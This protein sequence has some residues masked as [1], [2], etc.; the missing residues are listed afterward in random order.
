MVVFL[1]MWLV[2]LF[3]FCWHVFGWGFP[4]F[5]VSLYAFGRVFSDLSLG[6]LLGLFVLCCYVFGTVWVW[7]AALRWVA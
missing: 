6:C 7:C 3:R 2:L 4:L 5:V 1:L